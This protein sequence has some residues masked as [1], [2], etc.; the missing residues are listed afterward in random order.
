VKHLEPALEVV[1]HDDIKL[2]NVVK[3][4]A[5]KT[6]LFRELSKDGESGYTDLLFHTKVRWLSRENILNRV[7][8]LKTEL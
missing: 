5:L 1:I 3:G 8:A 4:H 2:V 7:W 6:R